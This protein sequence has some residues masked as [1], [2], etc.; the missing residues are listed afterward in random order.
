MVPAASN[1][2]SADELIP[3]LLFY[4]PSWALSTARSVIGVFMPPIL[5]TAMM[6]PAPSPLTQTLTHALLAARRYFTLFLLPPR[7]AFLADR[8]VPDAADAKTG[9]FNSPL[10]LA[11]PYYVKPTWASRWGPEA[12]VTW[13]LGGVV[14][15]AK[16]YC[17]EGYEIRNLG[18]DR[19]KGKGE[20]MMNG[21]E[22]RLR[23]MTT[24]GCPFAFGR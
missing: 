14:P 10:Y 23:E 1:K 11:H 13:G 19:Y 12:L 21:E 18:P 7:P 9:R 4:V 17:P 5:R 6:F 3:L 22:E 2:Q 16:K 8:Y 15:G 24:V 20:Q